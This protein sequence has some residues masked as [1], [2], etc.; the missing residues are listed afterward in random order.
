MTTK[1][2]AEVYLRPRGLSRRRSSEAFGIP[3]CT[4]N[5]FHHR[6]VRDIE[7][8]DHDARPP[9]ILEALS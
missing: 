3:Q 9:G 4:D 1:P 8:W 2:Q 6:Q 7:R 5:W